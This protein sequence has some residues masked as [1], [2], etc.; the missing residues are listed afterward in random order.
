[1][2]VVRDEDAMKSVKGGMKVQQDGYGEIQM[3]HETGVVRDEGA[4]RLV[5]GEMRVQ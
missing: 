4:M 1:M 2:G 3:C 5:W